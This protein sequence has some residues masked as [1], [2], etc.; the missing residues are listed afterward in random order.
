MP[1][2]GGVLGLRAKEAHATAILVILP[3]SAVS[4]AVY[5]FSGSWRWGTG[6]P[7]AAGIIAGGILGALLLKK[8]SN[9]VVSVIFAAIMVFAGIKMFF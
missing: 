3:L 4:A 5:A 9:K 1:V 7:A 2:L 6:L 8:L